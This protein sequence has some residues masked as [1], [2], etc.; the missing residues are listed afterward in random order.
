VFVADG[1]SAIYGASLNELRRSPVGSPLPMTLVGNGVGG[2]YGVSPD[3]SFVLFY[4]S[5][6]ATHLVSDMY[7]SSALTPT[8]PVTLSAEATAGVRGD[9]FTSDGSH[10]L[11]FTDIEPTTQT[12]TLNAFALASQAPKVLAGDVSQTWAATGSKIVFN[13]HYAWTGRR[14][15]ADVRTVDAAG[16]TEPEL[17]V[18]QAD[19]EVFLSPARDKIVYTWS[20]DDGPRAGIYV[21]DIP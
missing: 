5:M 19:S 10:V 18:A 16:N 14:V 1:E 13:D 15:H 21:V 9:A 7:L 6:D 12:G 17:I 20:L 2:L 11:Y 4:G 8:T 3:E